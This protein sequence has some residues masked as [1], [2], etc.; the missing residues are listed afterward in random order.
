[1]FRHQVRAFGR[2]VRSFGHQAKESAVWGSQTRAPRRQVSDSKRH[3]SSGQRGLV[4]QGDRN[5][6]IAR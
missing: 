3:Q 4:C 2:Q 5:V 1:M 6:P